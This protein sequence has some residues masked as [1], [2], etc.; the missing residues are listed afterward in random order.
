MSRKR[1]NKPPKE[2][3][4]LDIVIPVHNCFDI[5]K[6]GLDS[7]PGAI[8]DTSHKVIII[9]N[10]SDKEQA[11]E[12]Y[13]DYPDY[14]IIRNRENHGFPKTCNMGANRGY[15]PLILFLNSDVILEPGSLSQLISNMNDQ[16]IGVAGM[17][18]IF[19]MDNPLPSNEV[20]RPRGKIQHVGLTINIRGEFPHLFLGWSPD[21][22]KVNKVRDVVGVTGAAL[23]T[24][25]NIFQKAGRFHEGYGKG[26]Y[27]DLDYCF[28]VKNLGYNIIVDTK[29]VA[30]HYTN[31]TG[32][33]YNM[34]Y[35]I[36][37]NK[38]LFY[39]R[40]NNHMY[41]DEWRHW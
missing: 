12:F 36:Q 28:T 2:N 27:E 17:K 39:Q 8:E 32:T 33:T 35:P 23:L 14:K 16:T 25:R 19:P 37:A 29:A 21:H 5:L 18:L 15:S 41:W 22:P 31:A 4:I 30:Y 38:M 3:T 11:D 24:R 9:D 1:H 40:W 26:T 6:R 20:V 13:K 34:S 10:A 7:I